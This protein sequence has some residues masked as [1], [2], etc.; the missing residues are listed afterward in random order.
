VNA[1]PAYGLGIFDRGEVD[2]AYL[3]QTGKTFSAS[4]DPKDYP[5]D[6]IQLIRPPY[7]DYMVIVFESG[8]RETIY[9]V[10]EYKVRTW[11]IPEEVLCR[12]WTNHILYYRR[13]TGEVH[14]P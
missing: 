4:S 14:V 2:P 6:Y 12:A 9:A 8:I 3:P 5:K 13:T 10:D 7:L 1:L 11:D